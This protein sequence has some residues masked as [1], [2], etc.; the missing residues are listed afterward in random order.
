MKFIFTIFFF[1]F[2][3]VYHPHP[4]YDYS[5]DPLLDTSVQLGFG[6]RKSEWIVFLNNFIRLSPD[7]FLI[8]GSE[9]TIDK[10]DPTDIGFMP[11][12][13]NYS[14][15]IQYKNMGFIHDC[16]HDIDRH[17]VHQENK[18]RFYIDL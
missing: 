1:V 6:I 5:K 4:S 17:R 2:C 7:F 15:G 8:I 12:Q 14:F 13:I 16:A 9:S 11:R 10:K 3:F 18:N